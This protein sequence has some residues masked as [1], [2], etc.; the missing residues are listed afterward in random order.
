MNKSRMNKLALQYREHKNQAI[1]N[2]L[3]EEVRRY[4]LKFYNCHLRGRISYCIY[5][6]QDF[7][8]DLSYVAYYYYDSYKPELASFSTW[9]RVI[10]SKSISGKFLKE[11]LKAAIPDSCTAHSASGTNQ[12]EDCLTVLQ[13]AEDIMAEAAFEE[14]EAAQ[15]IYPALER[16]DKEHHNQAEAVRKRFLEEKSLEETAAEMGRNKNTVSTDERRGLIAMRE[17]LEGGF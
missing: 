15:M 5:D 14:A 12:D 3:F 6:D 13:I 8:Q 16:I 4:G 10:A 17:E 1:A 7:A 2:E 9:I 11:A